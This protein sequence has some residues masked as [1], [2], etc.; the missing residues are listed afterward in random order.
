MKPTIKIHN[1]TTGEIIERDMN[2]EE[3]KVYEETLS[4]NAAQDKAL[5]DKETEKLAL[6]ERLG[7]TPEE[8][9]TLLA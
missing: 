6:A 5:K 4:I 7:L 1:L 2:A 9:V 3:I 8:L